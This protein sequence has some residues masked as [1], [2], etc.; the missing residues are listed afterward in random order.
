VWPDPVERVL[1]RLPGVADVAI[2]GR[3]DAEWGERVV[4]WIVP[5]G[6]PPTL[7]ELRDA[8]KAELAPWCAPKELVIVDDL[9]RTA[10]GKVR[11]RGGVDADRRRQLVGQLTGHVQR[12][13]LGDVVPTEVGLDGDAADRRDVEHAAPAVAEARFDGELRPH[14]VAELVDPRRLLGGAHV[15]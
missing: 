4:A 10:L 8:V 14:Q 3:P 5:S 7:G 6:P 9:P 13:R 12:R 15:D 11:R 2:A 1:R